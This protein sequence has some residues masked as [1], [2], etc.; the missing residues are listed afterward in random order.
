MIKCVG[1]LA[2]LCAAT[3]F[4]EI[5]TVTPGSRLNA[6]DYDVGELRSFVKGG[7]VLFCSD[8]LYRST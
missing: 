3:A 7:G 8:A 4:A 6:A 1:V 5:K 2:A